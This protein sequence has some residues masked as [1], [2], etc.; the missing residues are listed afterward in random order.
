MLW[1]SDYGGLM[2]D[3]LL[4]LEIWGPRN[5]ENLAMDSI[6]LR[7][8]FLA[9]NQ[10]DPYRRVINDWMDQVIMSKWFM[11]VSILQSGEAE[12][13]QEPLRVVEDHVL[14]GH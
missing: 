1:E 4:G 14:V 3:F 13:S 12:I 5:E 11:A 10:G 8:E 7:G 2:V 6:A 9:Y